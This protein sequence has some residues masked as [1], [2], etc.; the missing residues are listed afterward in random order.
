MG[1]KL[2]NVVFNLDE[3]QYGMKDRV[4][5]MQTASGKNLKSTIIYLV[6]DS[7]NRGVDKQWIIANPS[8]TT[9]QSPSTHVCTT[10]NPCTTTYVSDGQADALDKV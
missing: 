9:H 2:G 5:A 8:I 6:Q 10:T 4:L 7:L 3:L 1:Q